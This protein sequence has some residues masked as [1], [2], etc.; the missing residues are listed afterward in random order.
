MS[1]AVGVNAISTPSARSSARSS[2][3]VRGYASRS[4]SAPNC[5]GLTKIDTTT[6]APWHPL[7]GPDSVRWPSCRA[8]IVGTSITRRPVVPQRPGDIG[9]VARAGVDVEFTGG[10]LRRLANRHGCPASASTAKTSFGAC[11]RCAVRNELAR[12]ACASCGIHFGERPQVPGDRGR[13]TAGDRSGQRRLPALQRVLQRCP[14]QRTDH[15]LGDAAGRVADQSP[16]RAAPDPTA[17]PAAPRRRRAA[18]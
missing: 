10:E 16:A 5:S 4:S 3:R 15:P 1:A 18:R 14:R 6:T 17:P 8:P 7:G 13:V 12:Y 2:S 11:A 9:D